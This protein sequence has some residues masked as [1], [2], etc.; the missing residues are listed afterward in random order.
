MSFAYF[1]LGEAVDRQGSLKDNIVEPR[2]AKFPGFFRALF[3]LRVL[4]RLLEAQSEFANPSPKRFAK[5]INRSFFTP[6][7][8]HKASPALKV[9]DGVLSV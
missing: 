7:S 3:W 6:N 5:A 9:R 4:R 2:N 8:Q 1:R